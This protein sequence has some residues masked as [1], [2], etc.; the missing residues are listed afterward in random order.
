M[1]KLL[2]LSLVLG[3]ASLAPAALHMDVNYTDG[4]DYDGAVLNAG[5]QLHISIIADA[6]QASH[7]QDYAVL[8]DAAGGSVAGGTA[9]ATGSVAGVN[10]LVILNTLAS[11][12][13]NVPGQDHGQSAD[14]S[15]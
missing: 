2:V 12:G 7:V 13:W 3:I 9:D 1:K 14:L 10:N 5:D 6:M 8:L 4:T 15:A 11:A